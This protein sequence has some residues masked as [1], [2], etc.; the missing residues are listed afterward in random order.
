MK[1][2]IP[3]LYSFI[4]EAIK[5]SFPI[6]LFIFIVCLI[7]SNTLHIPF[8]FDDFGYL[9]NDSAKQ[10]IKFDLPGIKKSLFESKPAGRPLSNLSFAINFYISQ[11]HLLGYHITN[12]AIH[13]ITGIFLYLFFKVTMM[14]YAV[15]YTPYNSSLS[16][17][18]NQI[19]LSATLLWLVHPINT[20]S[21]TYIIQRM[22]SLAAMFYILSLYLYAIG[23]IYFE[24]KNNVIKIIFCFLGCFFSV[25]CALGSKENAAS[26]P[27]MII[28]YEWFFFQDLTIRIKRNFLY[29]MVCSI[30]LL[31]I[32]LFIY[33]G[34]NLQ[35]VIVASYTNREFTMPERLMSECRVIIYYISLFLYPPPFRLNLDYSYPISHAFLK[36]PTTIIALITLFALIVLAIYSA[37]KNRLLSF[38]I[39]WFLGNLLIESS[40]IGIEII[41]EHRTYLPYMMVCL[42][43]VIFLFRHCNHQLISIGIISFIIFIFSLWTYQ[44]NSTWTDSLVFWNDCTQKSPKD[45]RPILNLGDVYRGI[46]NIDKAKECY[47]KSILL[48]PPSAVAH[49]NLGNILA[50][51]NNF[52]EAIFHYSKAIEMDPHAAMT[53][54]NL[55]NVYMQSGQYDLAIEHYQKALQINPEYD[56]PKRNLQNLLRLK[57]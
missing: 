33:F 22:T 26:L 5:N 56:L 51:Q 12:I 34:Q 54:N 11:Y 29:F 4:F 46:G 8:F 7:Y 40:V 9:V 3:G 27:M 2:N 13:M 35:Q 30:L 52:N 20:E 24:N 15:Q 31:G 43:F 25:L 36:P 47:E 10:L 44:R 37:K 6:V 57:K 28:L 21:V 1:S 45:S 38:C 53:H 23:R 55:A 14:K 42:C 16:I 19:I 50:Q 41:Y 49:N 48:P 17:N 18:D 32:I 39:L